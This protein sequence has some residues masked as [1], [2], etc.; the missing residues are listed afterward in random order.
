MN[1]YPLL[2]A[3]YFRSGEQT[4][5]G[6]SMLRDVFFKETP[7]EK[8]GESLEVSALPGME[9]V[10]RNG[11]HAG[12]TLPRMIELW[13]KALTGEYEG[14]FPLMLKLL[15]ASQNLS[16]QVHPDDAY[17]AEHDGTLGKTEA[18]VVLYA[19]PGAKI[20]YGLDLN[21]K[22][23]REI[24]EEGRIEEVL[25][26][27]EVRPGDVLYTPSG[28]VHA[29][30]SGVVVYEIQQSSNATYRFYDWNRIGKDG[31]SRELHIEK[32]LDVSNPDLHPSKI[33]G[34]TVL[35]KG[36]SRTYYICDNH[37]ELCRLNVSGK[38]PL[39]SGRM[40]LLTPMSPCII[41]WD[42]ESLELNP[43][44]SV[45]IPAAMEGVVIEGNAKILMSCLPDKNALKAELDYRAENVAGLL[46]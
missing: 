33:E 11:L 46:D 20:V 17:A 44:D 14:E 25:H 31:Q 36:G 3:P 34:T 15:D 22:D 35:C 37:F 28:M 12:K 18:W 6:G 45:L 8:T 40:L 24:A 16:V 26:W 39:E 32:S 23:L 10:V 2:M 30:C 1:L 43:F 5:W 13:G 38:M 41:R 42:A 7:N 4:P 21:G 29:L 27:L 19:E 9:S